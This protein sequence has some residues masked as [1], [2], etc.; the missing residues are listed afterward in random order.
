MNNKDLLKNIDTV[1]LS[2]GGI[3]GISFIGIIDKLNNEELI[4]ISTVKHWIGTSAG[5]IVSFF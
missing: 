3:K 1:C 2:G 5:A 4:N